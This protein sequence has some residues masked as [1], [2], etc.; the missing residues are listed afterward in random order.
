MPNSSKHLLSVIYRIILLCLVIISGA[1][2]CSSVFADEVDERRIQISLSIFPRIIAVDNE[3]R[4][5]LTKDNRANLI[6]LY[7]TSKNKAKELAATLQTKIKNVAGMEFNSTAMSLRELFDIG[8][9]L[10]TAIYITESLSADQLDRV[11]EF[12]NNNQRIVFS[13]LLGDVERGVT[14]GISITS[15]VKP[16]FNMQTLKNAGIEI[17]ALLMQM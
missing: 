15:R 10:P 6:F 5:K 9:E 14:A 11:M 3:F 12:A 17:N 13:P 4:A 2:W 16:Y 7:A 8:K 1:L